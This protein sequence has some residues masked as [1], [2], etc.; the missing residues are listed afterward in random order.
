MPHLHPQPIRLEFDV[1][2]SLNADARKPSALEPRKSNLNIL[3][4]SSKANILGTSSKANILPDSLRTTT[5]TDSHKALSRRG[6]E[7]EPRAAPTSV[8]GVYKMEDDGLM[9]RFLFVEEV[10]TRLVLV[11]VLVPVLVLVRPPLS[12]T[13]AALTRN[14]R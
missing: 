7:R 14:A 13:A 4:A 12:R 5:T 11:L 3:G 10:R 9:Q 2:G 6:K 1:S 8:E